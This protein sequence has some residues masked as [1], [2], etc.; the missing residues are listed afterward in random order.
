MKFT[1]TLEFENQF[2]DHLSGGERQRVL[3]AKVLTQT[4]DIILL[5]EPTA[6]LDITHQEQIF[7]YSKDLCGEGKTVIAA[8]HDLKI[9]SR[10][11]SRLILMSR[12]EIV[13][14]GAPEQVLTSENLTK[15]YGINAL[16]YKNRLTGL[17]DFYIPGENTG[18]KKNC[19]I[20]VFH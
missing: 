5:D 15:V 12:G 19:K 2:I 4:T 7:K 9:A 10:Y 16:V 18:T 13:A 11:C 6:N 3:F 1:N 14:D 17:L 20:H 8:V